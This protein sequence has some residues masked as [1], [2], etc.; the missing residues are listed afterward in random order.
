MCF[1]TGWRMVA[2]GCLLAIGESGRKNICGGRPLAFKVKV[3]SSE[4]RCCSG[5]V[6]LIKSLCLQFELH[7][8]VV[9]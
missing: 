2:G 4:A 5:K 1:L 8:Q 9:G 3:A 6:Q 7:Y